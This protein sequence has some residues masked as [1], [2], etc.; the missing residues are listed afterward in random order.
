MITI[1][2][3]AI[4]MLVITLLTTIYTSCIIWNLE[5]GLETWRRIALICVISSPY[6]FLLSKP[7]R[8]MIKTIF[9]AK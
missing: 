3:M 6:L 1:K 7:G 9:N 5:T 8:D 4:T 2:R